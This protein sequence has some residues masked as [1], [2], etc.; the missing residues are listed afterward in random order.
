MGEFDR[1]LLRP[2][3]S[4]MLVV[5]SDFRLRRLGRISQGIITLL[6]GLPGWASM[7]HF[8]SSDPVARAVTLALPVVAAI[9]LLTGPYT[10][11]WS[12]TGVVA[13]YWALALVAQTARS[14][15]RTTMESA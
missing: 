12:D 8:S 5:G 15:G 6:I 7:R 4:F 11:S 10:A 14:A 2:A 3:S 1:V 9:V 13:A